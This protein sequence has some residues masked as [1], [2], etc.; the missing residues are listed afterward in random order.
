[1]CIRPVQ[2]SLCPHLLCSILPMLHSSHKDLRSFLNIQGL[3]LPCRLCPCHSFCLGILL[4]GTHIA[5]ILTFSGL[6]WNVTLSES[7]P[8]PSYR[9]TPFHAP[10]LYLFAVCFLQLEFKVRERRLCLLY[11]SIPSSLSSPWGHN[12][13]SIGVAQCAS[14]ML[15]HTRKLFFIKKNQQVE[16]TEESEHQQ[17]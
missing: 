10:A 8:S 15:K 14:N 7:F 1:M 3:F 11:L 6:C 2:V 12:T 5:H 4:P 9:I 16:Q 13:C 17:F